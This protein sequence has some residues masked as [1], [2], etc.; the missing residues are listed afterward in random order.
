MNFRNL[1]QKFERGG[2][3]SLESLFRSLERVVESLP[4]EKQEAVELVVVEHLENA[5]CDAF[6]L[7][8]KIESAWTEG[9]DR[10]AD[11]DE[12]DCVCDMDP[13]GGRGLASHE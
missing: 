1:A 6:G 7:E 10:C 3:G 4:E 9:D 2:Y 8:Q 12:E 11:C 13:A 5:L